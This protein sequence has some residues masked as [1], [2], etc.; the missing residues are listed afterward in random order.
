MAHRKRRLTDTEIKEIQGWMES[1]SQ[2]NKPTIGMIARKY[3]VNKPSV[4]KSL[5]GWDGIQRGRPP[6]SEKPKIIKTN[7]PVVKIQEYTTKIEG[8]ERG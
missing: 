3:G 5:N 7:E 2:G 1:A 4:I 8:M 6:E